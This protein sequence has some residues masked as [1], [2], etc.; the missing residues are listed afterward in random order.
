MR[1]V[2]IAF[3]TRVHGPPSWYASVQGRLE[4]GVYHGFAVP[5]ESIVYGNHAWQRD[6]LSHRPVI[7]VLRWEPFSW[8]A[9]SLREPWFS[10]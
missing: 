8:Y 2:C 10:V 9:S 1:P 5:P 4:V 7:S 3:V 6:P